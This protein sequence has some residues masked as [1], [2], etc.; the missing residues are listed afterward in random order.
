MNPSALDLARLAL[1]L[2]AALAFCA[3]DL[4]HFLGRGHLVPGLG[5][6]SNRLLVP[7]LGLAL[8]LLL[9]ATLGPEALRG[10]PPS[11]PPGPSPYLLAAGNVLG[12]AAVGFGLWAGGFWAA[13]DGKLFTLLAMAFP[14]AL[15]HQA[16]PLYFTGWVLLV[17]AFLVFVIL[18]PLDLLW[19]LTRRF[20]KGPPAPPRT[21]PSSVPGPSSSVP[22]PSRPWRVGLRAALGRLL[23]PFLTF[24]LAFLALR[25]ARLYAREELAGHFQLG[26]EALFL[27]L[28]F[29]F[30]GAKRLLRFRFLLPVSAG[31]VLVLAAWL[32]LTGRLTPQ[33]LAWSAAFSLGLVLLRWG[34]EAWLDRADFQDLPWQ[35]LRPGLIPTPA[36]VAQ[37]KL[38]ERFFQAFLTD[39]APDGLT[40]RQAQALRDW[41]ARNQPQGTFQVSK[42]LP[43]APALLLGLLLTALFGEPLLRF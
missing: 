39:L 1:C 20:I 38:R 41:Y 36:C 16:P 19:G 14:P 6:I 18:L 13:G 43:F 7:F 11:G 33:T 15:L 4:L 28:F 3:T 17:N 31:L 9:L 25:I 8:G 2:L 32:W 22:G 23:P 30:A 26:A 5:P 21:V 24:L 42:T 27:L 37:F 34:Y 10:Q 12:A 29:G 35:Q 40:L